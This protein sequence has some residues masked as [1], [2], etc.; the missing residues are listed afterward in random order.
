[1]SIADRLIDVTAGIIG[2]VECEMLVRD[3]EVDVD[4]EQMYERT[5]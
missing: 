5:P 1:M 3:V 2:F 4:V